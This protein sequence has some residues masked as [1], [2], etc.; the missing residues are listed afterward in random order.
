HT[1]PPPHPRP[2]LHH[3][4]PRETRGRSP[5]TLPADGEEHPTSR[6]GKVRSHDGRR[7]TS[8]ELL[9]GRDPRRTSQVHELHRPRSRRRSRR[10]NL[11]R[12]GHINEKIQETIRRNRWNHIRRFPR[13]LHSRNPN[14]IF[15]T[16]YR[17]LKNK[18]TRQPASD[19]LGASCPVS[20][21]Q[22]IPSPRP[23]L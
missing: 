8:R 23:F 13:S 15:P 2:N 3:E 4:I 1:P 14:Q 11:Q 19:A 9:D 21:F 5:R 10:D 7:G 18:A 16:R 17:N 12:Y 6:Q 22:V 20:K